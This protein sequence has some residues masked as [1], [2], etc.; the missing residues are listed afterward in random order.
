[1]YPGNIISGVNIQFRGFNKISSIPMLYNTELSSFTTIP[2]TKHLLNMFDEYKKFLKKLEVRGLEIINM[3][4]ISWIIIIYT[5]HGAPQGCIN[6][7]GLD[8]YALVLD[9]TLS[10]LVYPR[11]MP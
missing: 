3:S 7:F 8:N 1:M 6:F 11:E 4:I 9:F 10:H 2:R 5:N